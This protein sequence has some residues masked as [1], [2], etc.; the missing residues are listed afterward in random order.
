M[1]QKLIILVTGESC[2]GKDYC[3][4]VWV[5]AFI[6]CTHK[7]LTARVVSISDETKRAYAAA[8]GADLSRLLWDRAYKEQHRPALTTFF[9]G[10]ARQRPQLPEEH[11]LN[12]VYGAVDE[13]VLLIT[14]MR[15]KAPVAA[16]SHLV[17]DSR[18]LEVR[19]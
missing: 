15:D 5:S 1:E 13:D 19:V 12:V 17:P 9:Q 14:G 11:F 7:S 8:T 4:D 2:A 3:A 16:L 10:Q 18:L 6:R